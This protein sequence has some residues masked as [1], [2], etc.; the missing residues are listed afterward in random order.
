MLSDAVMGLQFLGQLPGFLHRPVTAE[1]ARASVTA[2]LGRRE[3]DFLAHVRQAVYARDGS[4]YREL[5]RHAGV[6]AGDLDGLV[7]RE[8][9]EGTLRILLRH[10]VYLTV[11]ELRGQRPIRRG[12][13]ET[14]ADPA[15]LA[16]DPG[17]PHLLARTGGSRSAGTTIPIHLAYV[18]DRAL[19]GCLTVEARGGGR[20]VHAVWGVPG[21]ALVVN[22]LEYSAFGRVGRWFSQIDPGAPS[23]HPRYRWSARLAWM[24][25]RVAGRPL[26]APEHV[27]L[28]DPLPIVRWLDTER[29][30]GRTPHLH[31]YTSA[32]VRLCQASQ[33]GGG[34]LAGVEFACVGE[35]STAA[36]LAIIRAT[37]ASAWPRYA[38]LE[39]GPVGFGC[40]APA[41]AD[42]LHFFHDRLA[43]IQPGPESPPA[44]LPADALLF[45][46]LRARSSPLTLLN[47]SLGDRAILSERACGCP[48]GALG[49][50][51]HLGEIR[52]FEK[53]TAGGMNVL[54]VDVIR[55]LEEVLP[56]RFGGG[57]ADYQLVEEEAANGRPRLTLRLHP[58]VGPVD[59]EAVVRA[60]LEAV[61]SGRPGRV[62][63]LAWAD[64]GLLRV[65]RQ[66]P[67]ATE[68]GKIQHLHVAGG[69]S[70]APR[71]AR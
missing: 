35:P 41:A 50:R 31:A 46:G 22:L 70:R 23:L 43:L 24:G 25:S 58:R 5:L 15:R 49:W 59:P 42:D 65:E 60:F 61:S 62:P 71:P 67:V 29:A 51:R 27:S 9:V 52:S 28:D 48:L 30:A 1:E 33:A 21:S 40:L 55:I 20:W 19:N 8:G 6:E 4:P 10:G 3:A 26:P 68:T 56:A 17:M 12:A 14:R 64:G 63:S 32:I 69:R 45:T 44:G 53:L 39:C 36:R 57:P 2:R 11:E 38:G 13:F 16:S 37:G 47:V 54:D 7:R 66:A 34:D 18:R